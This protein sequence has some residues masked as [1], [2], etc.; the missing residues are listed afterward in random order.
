V[1]VT[2]FIND[3]LDLTWVAVRDFNVS[4]ML[5]LV[6]V[7]M[8]PSS[9]DLFAVASVMIFMVSMFVFVFVVTM[10]KDWLDETLTLFTAAVE[11]MKFT[12]RLLVFISCFVG[13]ESL[14]MLNSVGWLISMILVVSVIVLFWVLTIDVASFSAVE[15]LVVLL[16]HGF[17]DDEMD[18]FT[19]V[20]AFF[21]FVSLCNF[22]SSL[23][24]LFFTGLMVRVVMSVFERSLLN[25]DIKEFWLMFVL[26]FVLMLIVS[27]MVSSLTFLEVGVLKNSVVTVLKVF[28]V[29]RSGLWVVESMMDSMLMEV[30][31]LDIML[32]VILVI[33]LGVFC[34]PLIV[35]QM[36]MMMR[37][38]VTVFL[39]IV[40]FIR[41]TLAVVSWVM[42]LV[43]VV[44]VLDDRFMLSL[45]MVTF[46]VLRVVLNW[47][48]LLE[49]LTFMVVSDL[50]FALMAES[51]VD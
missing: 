19:N 27:I 15:C 46:T 12:F 2:F 13:S 36:L 48:V 1:N 20:V 38:V 40:V 24:F 33:K 35:S 4:V 7:T 34:V 23:V 3:V 43:F 50:V 41:E 22:I 11:I 6:L 29:V 47:G 26:I 49:V 44:L 8:L 42:D 37:I 32:I 25:I 17:F 18:W 28:V 16:V 9:M 45:S 21:V 14:G 39:N 31:W 5:S 30:L 10:L 51:L